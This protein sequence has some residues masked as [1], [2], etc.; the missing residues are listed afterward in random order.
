MS[1]VGAGREAASC[2]P[3][4]A[5]AAA[6][7][8]PGWSGGRLAE[9]RRRRE[10]GEGTARGADWGMP[11]GGCGGVGVSL[12]IV[13]LWFEAE[14]LSGPNESESLSEENENGST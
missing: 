13:M 9:E 2:L 6:S 4:W 8:G 3:A 7:A 14:L 11:G 5:V 1:W 12:C 10:G